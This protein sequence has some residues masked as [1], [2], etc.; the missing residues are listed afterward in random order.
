[1]SIDDKIEDR[2]RIADKLGLNI[3]AKLQYHC[4]YEHHK[5]KHGSYKKY[6]GTPKYGQKMDERDAYILKQ[7]DSVI[8]SQQIYKIYDEW[9]KP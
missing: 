9:G 5:Q 1:M 6:I 7:I 3:N 4:F 2:Q 8:E